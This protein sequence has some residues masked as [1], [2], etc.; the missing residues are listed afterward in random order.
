MFDLLGDLYVLI[1]VQTWTWIESDLVDFMTEKKKIPKTL[2]EHKKPK[3]KQSKILF[4]CLPLNLSY[5]EKQKC[6]ENVNV[7]Q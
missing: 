6:K 7:R 1:I 5:F 4:F 3:P 2:A